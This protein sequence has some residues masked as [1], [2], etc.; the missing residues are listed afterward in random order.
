MLRNLVRTAAENGRNRQEEEA[1]SSETRFSGGGYKLGGD[2]VESEFIADPNA[3]DASE[4][5]VRT[6]TLWRDGF[7]I[8]DG[9]FHSYE[10]PESQAVLRLIM[11]G[12]APHALLNVLPDQR[13]DLTLEDKRG[14]D[15]APSASARAWSGEGHRLGAPVPG[16]AGSSAMPGEFPAAAAAST[17]S[18][19]A[20]TQDRDSVTTRFEVDQ[21]LPTTSVQIRLADGTRMVARMNLTHTVGDIRS[22]IN[23]SRP[24][25][26]TREY[27]IN[28]TFPN[29]TLA[30]DA[31]TI[32][33]EGLKNSVVL[34]RW[35]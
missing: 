32:E 16:D 35:A 17:S 33:E 22:F 11:N 31:K 14:E 20:T 4:L 25:N 3:Q 34:Q 23:A 2:E 21:N 7:T 10:D 19:P 27:T 26:R 30:D 5:V 29:R 15:Y 12:T 28:T 9:P 13:V 24:E 6:V 8:A 1:P 18:A